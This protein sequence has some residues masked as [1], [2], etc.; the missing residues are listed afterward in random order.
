MWKGLRGFLQL[1]VAAFGNLQSP[2]QCVG[3]IA[4]QFHHFFLRLYIELVVGK[5]HAAVVA[6][7]FASLDA[8]QHF[9]RPRIFLRDVMAIVGGDDRHRQFF[10]KSNELWVN[11][12]L[13]F[14]ALVLDFNVK[15]V[16]T[17]NVEIVSSRLARGLV[18]LVNQVGADLA[19][20]T[21]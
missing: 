11:A 3:Q 2:A 17:K 20:Q 9:M 5:T 21:G 10:G 19:A 7:R 4:K 14:D 13:D 18:L 15:A 6:H 8:Q 16:A 1:E 12:V